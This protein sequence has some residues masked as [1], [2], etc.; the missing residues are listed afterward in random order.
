MKVSLKN[1]IVPSIPLGVLL[2]IGFII[3][4]LTAYFGARFETSPVQ[5]PTFANNI[6]SFIY[7]NSFLSN[8]LSIA[9]TLLNAFLLGQINNR[10]TIIRTRTFLPIFT[11]MLL[12]SSWNETHQANS[13]HLVLTIITL[14][15]FYFFSMARDRNASEQA[16]VGSFLVSVSSL[17]VNPVILLIPICWIGFVIFQS[18]SLRTFLA[19]IFGT[20]APWILFISGKYLFQSGINFHQIINLTPNFEFNISAFSFPVLIYIASLIIILIISLIG[21]FS[22]SNSD[23]INTRNKLNFLVLLLLSLLVLSFIFRNQFALFL[24]LIALIFSLIFSHPFTLKHSNFY[25][26]IFIVFCFVNI[27]YVVSKYIL[28][29]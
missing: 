27:A 21:M 10:F 9:F 7:P 3:L 13:S 4:W 1:L 16:F 19:S 22:L 8:M 12:M 5:S 17:F 24:P 15:L 6:E 14:S 26:I 25:G 28:I 29:K 2:V 20:L 11:F 18:F 23:A